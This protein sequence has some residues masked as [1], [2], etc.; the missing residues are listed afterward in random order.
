MAANFQ[1]NG[2]LGWTVWGG[3]MIDYLL[4]INTLNIRSSFILSE[5]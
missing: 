3:L 5:L 2:Q 1:R 4:R